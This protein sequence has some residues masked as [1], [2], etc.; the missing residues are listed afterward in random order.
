MAKAFPGQRREGE[1]ESAGKNRGAQYPNLS[2]PKQESKSPTK[3]QLS[4]Y[5]RQSL[6]PKEIHVL[7]EKYGRPLDRR[8][9]LG[10]GG[11]IVGG[12][13]NVGGAALLAADF[14]V[15]WDLDKAYREKTATRERVCLNGLWRWQPAREVSDVVPGDRWGHYKVPA[16][17]PGRSNYIQEDCQTLHPHP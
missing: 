6:R 10:V 8:E 16:F 9:F 13:G 1:S 12:L 14:K 5:R 3:S 2:S 15:V 4:R 17:W 7:P 11:A